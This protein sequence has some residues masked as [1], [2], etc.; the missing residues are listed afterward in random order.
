MNRHE[1]LDLGGGTPSGLLASRAAWVPDKTALVFRDQAYTY[2]ELDDAVSAIGAGLLALGLTPGDVVGYFLHN[3]AEYLTAGLAA[4]RAGLVGVP[5]NS[6]FK[7]DFLR[8][9]LEQTGAKVIITESALG[10]AM[11]SLGQLPASVRTLIYLDQV[12]SEVPA[13]AEQVLTLAELLGRGEAH[14]QFPAAGPEDTNSIL[15]TSGTT[16]RSKG[17]VCPNLM[18]LMMAKEGAQAFEIT[19][20]DRLFTCFPM[21]HGMAT[22]LTCYA[23]FYAGATAI[24]SPGFSMTTFW[25]EVRNSEATQFNAL[26]QSCTCCC[27]RPS[28]NGTATTASPGC[29]PPRRRPTRSTGSRPASACT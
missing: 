18:G 8:Y 20:R 19:P 2:R 22:V 10:D 7:A 24:I 4:T 6:A 16:G 25:D 28:P 14:P 23:A 5:I 26:A 21:Y 27:R 12:P 17:V 15:F 29:S 13:G 9:P 11:R 3:R 1:L